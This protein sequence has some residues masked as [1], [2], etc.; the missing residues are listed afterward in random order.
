MAAAVLVVLVLLLLIMMMLPLVLVSKVPVIRCA[1]IL[2]RRRVL[3]VRIPAGT[4]VRL[5][6]VRRGIGERVRGSWWRRVRGLVG[7]CGWVAALEVYRLV[8]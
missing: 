2:R 7:V 8:E 3:R 4:L 5:R 6:R 1:V